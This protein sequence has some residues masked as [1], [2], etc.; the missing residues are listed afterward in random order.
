MPALQLAVLV[1]S[2]I[3]VRK[4]GSKARLT[5]CA[6]VAKM[7]CQILRIPNAGGLDW[8]IH[9]IW[10]RCRIKLSMEFRGGDVGRVA[11]EARL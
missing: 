3:G 6:Q 2:R 10:M 5:S 7:N 1:L 4:A 11:S 8:H 9:M